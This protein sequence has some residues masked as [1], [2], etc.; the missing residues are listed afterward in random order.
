[1]NEVVVI[2]RDEL[3]STIKDAVAQALAQHN[4][5][6]SIKP[7]RQNFTTEQLLEYL[8][9]DRGYKMSKSALYQHTHRGTI[10]SYKRGSRV[11]F[12]RVDIDAWLDEQYDVNKAEKR[13][14]EALSR[15][16]TNQSPT[17]V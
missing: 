14:T 1:M 4:K 9:K 2:S 17:K 10:P 11:W 5:Q 3:H 16:A 6:S 7:D 13:A 12:R 15:S 8:N